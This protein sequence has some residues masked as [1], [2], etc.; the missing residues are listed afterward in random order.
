MK[1]KSI[2]NLLDVLQGSLDKYVWGK[3]YSRVF[4]NIKFIN[5]SIPIFII[6]PRSVV[7]NHLGFWW[8]GFGES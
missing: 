8:R 4:R 2:L 5:K 6:Q 3:V 1:L 7:V